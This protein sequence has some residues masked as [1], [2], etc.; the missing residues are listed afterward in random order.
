VRRAAAAALCALL[1]APASAQRLKGFEGQFLKAG[2]EAGGKALGA[3]AEAAGRVQSAAADSLNPLQPLAQEFYGAVLKVPLIPYAL[4][5]EQERRPRGRHRLDA[6]THHI[7]DRVRGWGGSYRYST[8]SRIGWE[9]HWTA[10][11]EEGAQYDLHY[12]GGRAVAEFVDGPVWSLD[13]GLGVSGLVGRLGRGGPDFSLGA[14]CRPFPPFF[15]DAK[16]GAVVME[17]GTLGELRG[18]AGVRWRDAE[19]RAGYKALV[20]PFDTLAGP[21]IGLRVRL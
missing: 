12:V 10:Y 3:V 14:E 17:G 11:L 18:G 20:G 2:A 8:A 9:A 16:A 19:L 5:L 1:A 6:F 4:A 7:D 13:Y 21:E 15:L